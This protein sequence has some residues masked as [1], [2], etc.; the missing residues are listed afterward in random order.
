LG[1]VVEGSCPTSDLL[2]EL[3]FTGWNKPVSKKSLTTTTKATVT[4][5]RIYPDPEDMNGA[6]GTYKDLPVTT[7]GDQWSA[8]YSAGTE[9]AWPGNYK[10]VV[11]DSNGDTK[12]YYATIFSDHSYNLASKE[13]LR[14]INRKLK[15][16]VTEASA[17]NKEDS[18]TALKE[19]K[20]LFKDAKKKTHK[21]FDTD[22]L[23]SIASHIYK[24]NY[25][26]LTLHDRA[27]TLMH[28]YKVS[29]GK[30]FDMHGKGLIGK[31]NLA[32]IKLRSKLRK[33]AIS[34]FKSFEKSRAKTT[35]VKM[36]FCTT[37]KLIQAT[38]RPAATLPPAEYPIGF[39]IVY[40][41]SY[42]TLEATNGNLYVYGSGADHLGTLPTVNIYDADNTL[43]SSETAEWCGTNA[44]YGL[45]KASFKSIPTG[46]YKV[47]AVIGTDKTY[48]Q[49]I[50]VK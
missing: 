28:L 10:F 27:S 12:D 22:L 5:V 3:Y 29:Y 23:E 40:M 13:D 18:K 38:P 50:F 4:T 14:L 9:T 44:D 6:G 32:R 21:D 19:I 25:T 49:E 7:S 41:A 46:T 20:T 36:V 11:T 16:N 30:D 47:Q 24:L 31:Y 2:R 48:I 42:V 34:S 33:T 17:F 39:Q 1:T 45:W 35:S 8:S 15:K 43:V 37:G 26:T